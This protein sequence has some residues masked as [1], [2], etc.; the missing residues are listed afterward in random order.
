MV[1]FSATPFFC[2]RTAHEEKQDHKLGQKRNAD[3]RKSRKQ[4]SSES[5]SSD[6]SSSSSETSS[7][8]SSESSSESSSSE[9]ESGTSSSNGSDHPR[10]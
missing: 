6:D 3:I 4:V 7:S 8:S 10:R 5:G 9:E 2:F 1:L